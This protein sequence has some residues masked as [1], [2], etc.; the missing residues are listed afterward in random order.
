[1]LVLRN[2]AIA[3]FFGIGSGAIKTISREHPLSQQ[4]V[5]RTPAHSKRDRCREAGCWQP[6]AGFTGD[7]HSTAGSDQ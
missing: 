3:P 7:A 1:M 4:A 2:I 5:S 6:C